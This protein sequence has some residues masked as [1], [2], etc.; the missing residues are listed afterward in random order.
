LRV[1]FY[2]VARMKTEK[3]GATL[4]FRAATEPN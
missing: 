1:I 2:S 4:R 3:F